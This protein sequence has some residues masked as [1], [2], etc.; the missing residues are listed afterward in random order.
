MLEIIYN[1]TSI[2]FKPKNGGITYDMVLKLSRIGDAEYTDDIKLRINEL[3][4]KIEEVENEL[5][6]KYQDNSDFEE[7]ERFK[8]TYLNLLYAKKEQIEN[9]YRPV[10]SGFIL[11]LSTDIEC[12]Y[13]Y[14]LHNNSITVNREELEAIVKQIKDIC[15]GVDLD[16]KY[17][18][19]TANEYGLSQEDEI[20]TWES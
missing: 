9:E 16:I 19:Y 10:A 20:I 2:Y 17:R 18:L 12:A 8:Q 4:T 11:D 6:S 3:D 5:H 7:C 14:V 15:S 1:S 13:W